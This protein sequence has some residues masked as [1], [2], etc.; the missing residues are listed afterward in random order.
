MLR[1]EKESDYRT[2]TGGLLSLGIIATILTGF[3]SMIMDTLN[4]TSIS[5]SIDVMKN[6]DPTHTKLTASPDSNF[7]FAIEVWKHNLSAPYRY[8]DTNAYLITEQTGKPT[9]NDFPMVQCTP[10]HWSSMP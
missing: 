5:T 4:L 8:F 2:L 10:E 7:M 9:Y 6:T 1:Y 3:A